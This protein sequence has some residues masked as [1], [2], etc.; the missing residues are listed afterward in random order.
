MFVKNL[1]EIHANCRKCGVNSWNSS[2]LLE[3]K[4]IVGRNNINYG[5]SEIVRVKKG[6]LYYIR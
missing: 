2:P 5:T 3:I 4:L 1:S 6:F